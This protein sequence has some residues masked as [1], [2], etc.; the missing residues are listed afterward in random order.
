M[1]IRFILLLTLTL[2]AVPA[3]AEP[4]VRAE[5]EP[6][7]EQSDIYYNAMIKSIDLD[8]NRWK[9]FSRSLEAGPWF[10][11]AQG[12]VHNGAMAKTSV[13]VFPH[14]LKTAIYS[15]VYEHHRKIRKI[16]FETEINCSAQTYRQPLIIAYGY[17][18]EELIKHANPARGFSTIQKGT[19]TD[20]LQGLICNK[21]PGKKR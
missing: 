7:A 6:E 19:T 1:I 13:T 15:S 17:Y 12:V 20:T 21:R 3:T 8:K 9:P 5:E 11:D 18:N 2:H 10:Y 14:P 4:P 16:V